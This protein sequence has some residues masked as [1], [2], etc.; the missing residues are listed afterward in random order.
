MPSPLYYLLEV[1]A[2]VMNDRVIYACPWHD[3]TQIRSQPIGLLEPLLMGQLSTAPFLRLSPNHMRPL[4]SRIVGRF[5]SRRIS[6]F[7]LE[8]LDKRVPLPIALYAL[9]W[10]VLMMQR[11]LQGLPDLA[12]AQCKYVPLVSDECKFQLAVKSLA[13]QKAL[14]LLYRA[15]Y[16]A[17]PGTSF[18][19][20]VPPF[21]R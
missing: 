5:D 6:P 2:V 18:V 3:R 7:L 10:R 11:L 17:S 14:D 20:V 12:F 19:V 21:L 15:L 9:C 16:E 4:V 1:I 8:Q 13:F